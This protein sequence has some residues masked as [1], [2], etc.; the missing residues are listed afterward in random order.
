MLVTCYL[1]GSQAFSQ[2]HYLELSSV[3]SKHIH[4]YQID[5][6]LRKNGQGKFLTMHFILPSELR[7]ILPGDRDEVQDT[8]SE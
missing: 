3:S 7:H 4:R 8:D 2:A 6:S 5:D 1:I